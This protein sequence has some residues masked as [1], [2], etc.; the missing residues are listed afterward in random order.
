MRKSTKKIILSI[1]VLI[2]LLPFFKLI[3]NKV[4]YRNSHEV[5]GPVPIETLSDVEEWSLLKRDKTWHYD[6]YEKS[7][8][9]QS[10]M[11]YNKTGVVLGLGDVLDQFKSYDAY[12][13]LPNKDA[14]IEIVYIGSW[15]H[16]EF[17][18]KEIRLI[19]KQYEDGWLV[20]SYESKDEKNA[21]IASRPLQL[22]AP[23]APTCGRAL[24]K[25]K[26]D[27]K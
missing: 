14:R 13:G 17:L 5:Y 26:E 18:D 11:R 15:H 3:K 12:M 2:L 6:D 16:D 4:D 24:I 20:D 1:Y 27:G 7:Y 9:R 25:V 21:L 22:I 8:S 23:P 19:V 10:R